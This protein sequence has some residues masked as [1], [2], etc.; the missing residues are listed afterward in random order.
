MPPHPPLPPH[1]LR[2]PYAC[3]NMAVNLLET[4]KGRTGNLAS[5]T[6]LDDGD[7]LPPAGNGRRGGGRTV[8]GDSGGTVTPPPSPPSPSLGI[9]MTIIDY[10]DNIVS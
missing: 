7:A 2:R 5:E 10:D 3:I 9:R 4:W 8:E 1:P 6:C